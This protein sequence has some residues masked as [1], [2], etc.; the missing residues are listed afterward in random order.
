MV[1]TYIYGYIW[2][3]ISLLTPVERSVAVSRSCVR[4]MCNVVWGQANSNA[5][6]QYTRAYSLCACVCVCVCV[7][8][9][10]LA[11]PITATGQ[12][13][14]RGPDTGPGFHHKEQNGVVCRLYSHCCCCCSCCLYNSPHERECA[15]V[16]VCVCGYPQS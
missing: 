3:H 8:V 15:R 12:A 5:N 14:D 6:A 10:V 7:C 1:H 2:V 13:P 16:Y 9:G 11:K 4:H